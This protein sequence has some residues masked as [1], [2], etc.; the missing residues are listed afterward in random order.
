MN[1]T[2]RLNKILKSSGIK[3]EAKWCNTVGS[4]TVWCDYHNGHE[5]RSLCLEGIARRTISK[6]D[7][8]D[9]IANDAALRITER[10]LEWESR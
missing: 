3:V 2:T 7:D 5:Q 10:I 1:F 4:Y 9:A 8:Q 6:R